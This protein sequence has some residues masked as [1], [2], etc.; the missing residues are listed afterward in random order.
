MENKNFRFRP[1]QLLKFSLF[2]RYEST[3]RYDIGTIILKGNGQRWRGLKICKEEPWAVFLCGM[4]K[5]DTGGLDCRTK[6]KGKMAKHLMETE[7]WLFK[8]EWI[9]A[10]VDQETNICGRGVRDD[11]DACCG[12]S[13]GPLF[14]VDRE[15][16]ATCLYG[17]ASGGDEFCKTGSIFTRADVLPSY[18]VVDYDYEYYHDYEATGSEDQ[19]YQNLPNFDDM[20]IPRFPVI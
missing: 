17:V 2:N 4:G 6:K 12:D 20:Y 5:I 1:L 10:G 9:R 15:G 3:G 13:G 19:D 16:S 11:S 18:L 7:V 8:C 14:G